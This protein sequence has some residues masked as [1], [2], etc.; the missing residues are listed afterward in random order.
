MNTG[1][2]IM[3]NFMRAKH[4]KTLNNCEQAM[5]VIV[6]ANNKNYNRTKVEDDIAQVASAIRYVIMTMENDYGSND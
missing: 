3:N 4:K 5:L 1:E 2:Y 6:N